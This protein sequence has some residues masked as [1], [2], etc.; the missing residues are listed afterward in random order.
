MI[1]NRNALW[2]WKWF[3]VTSF[4]VDEGTV[5]F[6]VRGVF[7]VGF[8]TEPGACGVGPEF[9]MEGSLEHDDLFATGVD[10]R[11]ELGVG[12]PFD[13]GDTFEPM[14]VERHYGEAVNHTLAPGLIVLF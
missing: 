11:V 8:V 9:V 7:A 14:L 10:V 3:E 4:Y 12:F 6:G 1:L 2:L 5:R 13:E